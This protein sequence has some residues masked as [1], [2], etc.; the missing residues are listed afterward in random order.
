MT[1]KSEQI[2]PEPIT[3]SQLSNAAISLVVRGLCSPLIL[4]SHERIH[5]KELRTR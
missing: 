5:G 2:R 1:K 3:A 4:E